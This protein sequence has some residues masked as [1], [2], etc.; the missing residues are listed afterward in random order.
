[1]SKQSL[2]KAARLEIS[3]WR[4]LPRGLVLAILFAFIHRATEGCTVEESFF[5]RADHVPDYEI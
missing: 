3:V 2:I 1:M 4:H 5:T